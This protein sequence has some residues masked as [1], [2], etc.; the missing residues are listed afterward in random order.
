M[1]PVKL[2]YRTPVGNSTPNQFWTL[3]LLLV[4]ISSFISPDIINDVREEVDRLTASYS[5]RRDL[6]IK[7]TGNTPRRMNNVDYDTIAAESSFLMDIYSCPDLIKLL[8]RIAG[9]EVHLCPYDFEKMVITSLQKKGDSHGW[10]WDDYSFA[11]IWVLR[12]PDKEKGGVV[13]CV[14]NTRWD[15]NNPAIISQFVAQ[16]I[17]TYYFPQGS[18]YLMRSNSTLHRVYPLIDPTAVRTILNNT[19]ASKADLSL[20][21]DHS[22]MEELFAKPTGQNPQQKTA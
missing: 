18:I 21:V 5:R 9:E 17:G 3:P 6:S 11:M 10:H 12:A 20:E 2:N 22:S 7:T 13:Q 19:Y 4:Q 15:R 16:D 14:P 8:M 1:K